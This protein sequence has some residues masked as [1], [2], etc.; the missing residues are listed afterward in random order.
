M[1]DLVFDDITERFFIGCNHLKKGQIVA[2]PEFSYLESM[3]CVELLDPRLDSGMAVLSLN[4]PVIPSELSPSQIHAFLDTTF[5]QLAQWLEGQSLPHTLYSSVFFQKSELIEQ[6]AIISAIVSFEIYISETLHQLIHTT[7]CL[8]EDDYAYSSISFDFDP[9]Y[10]DTESLLKKAEKSIENEEILARIKFFGG[11]YSI[12]SALLKPDGLLTAEGHLAFTQKQLTLINERSSEDVSYLFDK[13]FCLNKLPH[14]LPNKI[15]DGKNYD[16]LRA[17]TRI[18]NFLKTIEYLL[19]LKD[20]NDLEELFECLNNLPSFDILSR[21]LYESVLFAQTNSQ[22][23]IFSKTPLTELIVKSMQRFGVDTEF[24]TLSEDFSYYLGRLEIVFKEYTIL[25]LKNKTRQQR[26]LSKYL[27]DFN[28][29][30]TEGHFLT[31]KTYGK[32]GANPKPEKQLLFQWIFNKTT[33]AMIEYLKYSFELQ[34]YTDKDISIVM[35]YLDFL[36]GVIFSNLKSQGQYIN[37]KQNKRKIKKKKIDIKTNEI[38]NKYSLGVQFLCRGIVRFCILL[39]SFSNNKE[40]DE[41]EAIRFNKRFRSFSVIQMPQLIEYSSYQSIKSIPENLNTEGF[42]DACKE[43]FDFAKKTLIEI[44]AAKPVKSLLRVCVKNLLA[45][46]KAKKLE[47]KC[48]V[49]YEF[50]ED[51]VFPVIVID[52]LAV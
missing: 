47:W 16:F 41:I 52:P 49:S 10:K 33:R 45:L 44:E 19:K 43:C 18:N 11:L 37:L 25:K 38:E 31:E 42:M 15:Y 5:I 14:F 12:I 32:T 50:I 23:L 28:I 9:L 30:V 26:I 6:N 20:I 13:N 24:L 39:N 2:L 21:T 40:P 35:F 7:S 17:Q 46:S 27:S 22:I 36:Y 1:S 51:K 29:L 3:S 8:R 48:K 4:P 34:L